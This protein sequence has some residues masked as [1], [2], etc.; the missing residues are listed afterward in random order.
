MWPGNIKKA[1]GKLRANKTKGETVK[2]ERV[3]R[4]TKTGRLNER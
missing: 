3:N 4:L 1:L 2:T